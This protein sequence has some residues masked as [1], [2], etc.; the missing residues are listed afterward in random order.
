M[1]DDSTTTNLS[2]VSIPEVPDSVD[3][4]MHNLTDAPTKSMGQTLSSIWD[5]VF[6]PINHAADKRRIKYAIDLEQYRA[7]LTQSIEQIPEEKK[8]EPDIQVAAQA[9]ENSK[10]CIS[11][12]ILRK[13][14]VNLISGSMNSDTQSLAHPAFPEI[15]KQLSPDDALLLKDIYFSNQPSLPIAKVG[16]NANNGGHTMFYDNLF[17]PNELDFS[18]TKCLLSLSSLERAN[19]IS[20]SYN[21]WRT[22]DSAYDKL[23][24]TPGYLE[25]EKI[26]TSFQASPPYFSKGIL[27]LTALGRVFCSICIGKR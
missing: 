23:R 10:Y 13:M 5:L 8:I 6:G 19:L 12:D 17:V 21:S 22:D 3:N 26:S 9:L 14:F 24:H 15:L 25:I 11:S 18:C 4:A 7:Q 1:S 2:L 16:L 20:I 27:Q